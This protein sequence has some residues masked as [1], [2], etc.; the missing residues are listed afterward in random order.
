MRLAHL[1][2]VLASSLLASPASATRPESSWAS[3]TGV[4]PDLTLRLRP[5]EHPLPGASDD[6]GGSINPLPADQERWLRAHLEHLDLRLHALEG[7]PR[8]GPILTEAAKGLVLWPALG[9]V[10][11]VV[12]GLGTGTGSQALLEAIAGAAALGAACGVFGVVVIALVTI[13]VEYRSVGKQRNELLEERERWRL[14][15]RGSEPLAPS[16]PPMVTVRF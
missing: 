4:W 3:R 6:S 7:E 8:L 13:A 1:S 5:A 9:A 12:F 2:L 15:L 14:R 16:S 11:G 10:V